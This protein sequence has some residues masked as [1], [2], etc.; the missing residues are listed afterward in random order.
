MLLAAEEFLLFL[1]DEQHGTLLPMTERTEHLV[2]AGA[3]LMDLQLANRIDTDL[4]SL[5]PG[6]PTPLGDDV[7][8]PVLADIVGAEETHDAL[9]WVERTARRGREIRERTIARLVS[10]GILREPGDDAFLFLT[11]EVA[12]ARRYPSTNGAAQEHVRLRIMRALFTDDIPD[13]ADIVIVSLVDACDV[14]RKLLTTE[15]LVKAG[16]RIEIISRLDLIGRAVATLVRMAR[17]TARAARDGAAGLPLAR[18]WPLVGS[19]FAVARDPRTFFVREYRRLGPVFEVRT[20]TRDFVAL[21]GQEAN[22]FVSRSERM[23]LHTSD[24]WDPLCA[25]FGASRFVLNMD[26]K[27][28]V[29]MRRETRDG[30]SRQLIESEIPEAVDVIR[31]SVAAMPLNAPVPGL[32]AILGLVSETTSAIVAQSSTGEYIDDVRLVLKEA[33]TRGFLHTPRWPKTPRLRRALGRAAELSDRWLT[34]HQLQQRA[35][36]ANAIDDILALHRA[37]PTFLPECDLPLT[38][39]LPLFAGVETVGSIGACMLYVVLKDPA[40]RE[41]AQAEADA[42]FAD[43]T[44]DASQVRDLDVLHRIMLEAL[45]MYTPVPGIQRKVT[46]SFDFAGHRIPVGADLLLAFFVTHDLPEYFPDPQ[47][48]DID[49]YLPGREEHRQPGVYAPFGVGV[50]HCAGR[51]FAETQLPLIVATLLHEADMELD[52]PTYELRTD[53]WILFP[54]FAPDKGFRFRMRS[55]RQ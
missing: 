44:P 15:E 16:R 9:Y 50:H 18:G 55:R 35:R 6:N 42:L 53:R 22:L 23:H 40:L 30:L 31:R 11:P 28:H 20:L 43:G 38:A 27:D 48:F 41:R 7:L 2:L 46:T 3:V 25:E 10:R 54:S 19:T 1:L 34:R 4:D 5:T 39:L 45:R 26:G 49:R 37:D 52:P 47:R 14:W 33:V 51:G 8:D 32:A 21:A 17:P 24:M 13:P 29:R 12:H 36:K